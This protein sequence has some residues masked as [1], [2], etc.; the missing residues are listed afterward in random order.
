[1]VGYAQSEN[2]IANTIKTKKAGRS[3]L[4]WMLS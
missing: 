4:L 2:L 3:L 1:M